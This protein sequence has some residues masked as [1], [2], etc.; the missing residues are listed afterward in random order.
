MF[1]LDD[2]VFSRPTGR[3]VFGCFVALMCS[4]TYTAR[5]RLS[6]ASDAMLAGLEFN[7]TSG[8]FVSGISIIHTANC[9]MVRSRRGQCPFVC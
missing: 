1:E 7:G 9:K 8:T 4:V 3:T 5:P 6:M 2:L